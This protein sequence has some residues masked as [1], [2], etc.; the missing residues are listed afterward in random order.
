MKTAWR[1][2]HKIRSAIA[3]QEPQFI[4]EGDSAN[5][6]NVSFTYGF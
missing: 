6:W 3:K 1:M 4:V 5:G 2:G